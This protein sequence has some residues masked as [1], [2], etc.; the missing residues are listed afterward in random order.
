LPR[1]ER[2]AMGAAIARPAVAVRR[3]M[4][5]ETMVGGSAGEE[6]IAR[7]NGCIFE[8][9]SWNLYSSRITC[10]AQI[11]DRSSVQQ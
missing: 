8:G 10:V 6:D 2:G 7:W 11:L 1:G 9:Q 5:E 3:R 4:D